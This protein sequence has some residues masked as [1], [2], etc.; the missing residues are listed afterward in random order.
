MHRL[1]VARRGRDVLEQKRQALLRQRERLEPELA[2]ARRSWEKDAR[3]A[4]RWW[5]L[6]AVLGGERSLELARLGRIE[7]ASVRIDWRNALGVVYP[8]DVDVRSEDAAGP[9]GGSPALVQAVAAYRRAL[10]SAA[11]L[12]AASSAWE[13]VGAELD[14]TGHRLRAIERRWIPRHEHAL[15]ELE[16]SLDE[17]ERAE[18]AQARWFRDRLRERRH[19][20]RPG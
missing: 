5:Q 1:E 12:A 15:A 2:E 13:R 17:S 10:S 8:A 11:R 14:A 20:S 16:L 19:V 6:A 9:V 7:P 18:I 4:E 3:E